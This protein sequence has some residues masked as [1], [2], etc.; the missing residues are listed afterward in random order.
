MKKIVW[1]C[2]FFIIILPILIVN[3]VLI[4]KTKMY[5]NKIAD[6]FGYRP[7]IVL[8]GS[9]ETKIN[10]GDLI[11]VKEIDAKNIKKGDIIAFKKDKIVISHRV[12]EIYNDDGGFNFTTKGDNNDV[13]DNFLV[14]SYEIQGVFVNKIPGLGNVLLFLGKPIGLLLVIL[15]IIIISMGFYFINFKSIDDV[16]K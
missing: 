16:R 14:N 9:M 8:S 4:V 11:I 10:I 6:F 13:I 5:P 15:I 12:V 3:V 1:Y 2:L 7:F